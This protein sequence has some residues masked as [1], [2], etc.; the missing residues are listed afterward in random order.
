MVNDGRARSE[1]VAVTDWKPTEEDYPNPDAFIVAGTEQQR[2]TI[3]R[4]V[5]QRAPWERESSSHIWREEKSGRRVLLSRSLPGTSLALYH[6]KWHE[7]LS[8]KHGDKMWWVIGK[9]DDLILRTYVGLVQ[10]LKERLG[11]GLGI[12]DIP[13]SG[14]LPLPDHEFKPYT[15]SYAY[16][17]RYGDNDDLALGRYAIDILWYSREAID[18]LGLDYAEVHPEHVRRWTLRSPGYPD[19]YVREVRDP[20]HPTPIMEI[21]QPREDEAPALPTPTQSQEVAAAM[22]K[23]LSDE[24]IGPLPIEGEPQGPTM[25]DIAEGITQAQEAMRP[26]LPIF[27]E[28]YEPSSTWWPMQWWGR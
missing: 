23:Y 12:T 6:L 21:R 17:K 8:M 25:V 11:W 26:K 7:R 24:L 16:N 9:N 27:I 4:E 10:K 20:W 19:T 13:W 15:W 28:P 5:I 3:V 18:C 2:M 14:M 1:G 22:N